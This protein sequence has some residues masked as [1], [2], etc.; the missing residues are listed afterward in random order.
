MLSGDL[1]EAVVLVN[2]VLAGQPTHP[3]G[4]LL[5]ER[6]YSLGHFAQTEAAAP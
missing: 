6:L 3:G 4:L 2:A 5:S 1:G